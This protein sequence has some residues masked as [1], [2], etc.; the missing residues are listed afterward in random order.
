MWEF[1]FEVVKCNFTAA[2][3]AFFYRF[4]TQNIFFAMKMINYHD[5]QPTP[6]ES[7]DQDVFFTLGLG[8]HHIQIIRL[9]FLQAHTDSYHCIVA[10]NTIQWA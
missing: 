5:K 2:K 7:W 4:L 9:E 8:Y 1:V 10:K 6:S 3:K